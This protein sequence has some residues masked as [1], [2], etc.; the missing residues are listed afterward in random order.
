[1]QVT[2]G[3]RVAITEWAK[4]CPEITEVWLYGS[5]ARGT[6]RDDSD[7]NLAVV[8]VGGTAGERLAEKAEV[9]P[10]NSPLSVS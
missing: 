7:I 6:G 9:I 3:D 4:D 8:T 1:M 2:D 5:R 10:R